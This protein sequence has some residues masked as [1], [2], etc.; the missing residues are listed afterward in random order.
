M[1]FR[2]FSRFP[3]LSPKIPDFPGCA[4]VR[5]PATYTIE[6]LTTFIETKTSFSSNPASELESF[7][8][9][10]LLFNKT[11]KTRF[12]VRDTKYNTQLWFQLFCLLQGLVLKTRTRSPNP[13]ATKQYMLSAEGTSIYLAKQLY[14]RTHFCWIQT[15]VS[16]WEW[17]PKLVRKP[18]K[19]LWYFTAGKWTER[20][21]FWKVA[22]HLRRILKPAWWTL[23]VSSPSFW[24]HPN[25]LP[26]WEPFQC[27]LTTHILSTRNNK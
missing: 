14:D 13:N 26:R 17:Y 18:G 2:D 3:R 9:D 20:K 11:N 12:R 5:Y 19:K 8:R 27:L 15:M 25:A 24:L 6:K 10:L 22:S 21:N 1:K 16:F 4:H 23:L 7:L